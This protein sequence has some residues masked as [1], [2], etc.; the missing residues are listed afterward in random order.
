MHL[1]L[2]TPP[3]PPHDSGD[4]LQN[5]T[6][7]LQSAQEGA[8]AMSS[9]DAVHQNIPALAEFS[10]SLPQ[11]SWKMLLPAPGRAHVG[12]NR[13]DIALQPT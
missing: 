1:K 3:L 9:P 12:P 7:H 4:G 10:S 13:M 5:V 2:G 11:R 6:V 8:R